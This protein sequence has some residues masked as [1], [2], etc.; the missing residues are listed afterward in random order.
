MIK[1][2]LVLLLVAIG[3]SMAQSFSERFKNAYKPNRFKV[4]LGKDT[5]LVANEHDTA[6][7]PLLSEEEIILAKKVYRTIDVYQRLMD[8]GVQRLI[9]DPI[10]DVDPFADIRVPLYFILARKDSSFAVD[11]NWSVSRVRTSIA[12]IQGHYRDIYKGYILI[13]W[14]ENGFDSTSYNYVAGIGGPRFDYIMPFQVTL[15][16]LKNYVSSDPAWQEPIV[17]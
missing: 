1:K 13:P 15:D 9:N 5:L 8:R 16:S 4:R 17:P 10:P 11:D 12:K 14:T 7:V 2:I 3:L 6:A